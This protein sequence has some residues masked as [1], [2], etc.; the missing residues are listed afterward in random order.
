MFHGTK[1]YHYCHNNNIYD[2][3]IQWMLHH[4]SSLA[5]LTDLISRIKQPHTNIN[6]LII[7]CHTFNKHTTSTSRCYIYTNS[8][9]IY[10][11][12]Y[13]QAASLG[14]DLSLT[15][16]V[17]L[18]FFCFSALASG[19]SSSESL[20]SALALYSRL[21]LWLGLRTWWGGVTAAGCWWGGGPCCWWRAF[22]RIRWWPAHT[23]DEKVN[24]KNI[25][26]SAYCNYA[27]DKLN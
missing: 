14:A 1:N 27:H 22:W 6:L 24:S 16:A 21:F 23:R 7:H 26:E 11:T 9:I 19:L 18:S 25:S 8:S 10:T 20:L 4:N 3:Q 13:N 17:F 5:K 12:R 2:T 15:P